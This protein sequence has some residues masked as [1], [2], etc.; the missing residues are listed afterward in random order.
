MEQQKKL[1]KFET[2]VFAEVDAKVAQIRQEAEKHKI[3][4]VKRNAEEQKIRVANEVQRQIQDLQKKSKRE[5][6]KF[7]LDAKRRIL[8]QR[9][10]LTDRI[11]R[12]AAEKL[13][14]FA[15][16]EQYTDYLLKEIE[17]FSKTNSLPHV[18]VIVS[19][20][21][22]LLSDR[23]KA[24][25][26]LPCEV[27]ADKNISGGFIVQDDRANA[28]FDLT[29]AQKLVDQRAYFIENSEFAL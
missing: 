14:A 9:G 21:D 4:Q 8:Q 27:I 1:S 16:T 7:G 25:Y 23:I 5:I 28:Y 12:N 18:K 11:F 19:E 20:Q 3:E 22:A 10:E 17:E 29:L 26:A 6:A 24:A 13:N 15:K 2:A